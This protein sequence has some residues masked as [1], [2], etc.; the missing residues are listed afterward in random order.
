[1]F[2][3]ALIPK[4]QLETT[5]IVERVLGVSVSGMRKLRGGK[6]FSYFHIP[7]RLAEMWKM[8]MSGFSRQVTQASS[9]LSMHEIK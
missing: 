6:R 1:M 8:K 4:A 7:E 2:P 3:L 9:F 5:W